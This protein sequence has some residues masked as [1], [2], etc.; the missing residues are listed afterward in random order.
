MSHKNPEALGTVPPA[1]GLYFLP[2]T[3]IIKID[4]PRRNFYEEVY[5]KVFYYLILDDL[6]YDLKFDILSIVKESI[7][8]CLKHSNATE[9]WINLI[10]QPKFYSIVIRD[11]GTRYDNDK[12]KVDT[13]IGLLSMDDI[14]HKYN[15]FLNYEFDQGFKI[16]LTLMKE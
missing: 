6:V 3:S 10:D 11:N 13:G 16:H 8:N 4:L 12:S 15:G 7:N 1:S 14:A 5:R 2:C 9:L